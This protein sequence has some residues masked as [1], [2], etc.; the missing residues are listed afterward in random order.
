MVGI[1]QFDE[2]QV[3]REALRLFS[4]RGLAGT[5]MGDLT[6]ATSV[7]RGS[8]YNAY[9][10]KDEIYILAFENYTREVLARF[11]QA[12]DRSTLRDALEGVFAAAF[13]ALQNDAA[14]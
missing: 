1:R 10:D 9:G 3:I 5:T 6:Q 7:Q 12:L 2:T 14:A 4:D 11:R 13:A 8:L